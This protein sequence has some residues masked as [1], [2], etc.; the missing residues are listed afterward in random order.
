MKTQSNWSA[1]AL[2]Y[3]VDW[4]RAVTT[5]LGALIARPREVASVVPSS[6]QLEDGLSKLVKEFAPSLVVELGPGTGGTTK[7][8]L[9][10]LSADAKLISIEI[11]PEFVEELRQI[12]DPRLIVCQGDAA[13]LSRILSESESKSVDLVVSGIPFSTMRPRVAKALVADIHRSLAPGGQ[14]VTYQVRDTIIEIATELFNTPRVSLVFWNVPPLRLYQFAKPCREKQH[15]HPVC[16]AMDAIA[17][18]TSFEG[19]QD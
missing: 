8:L 12:D 4:I 9:R 2:D 19:R 18:T 10:S 5:F 6:Q 3:V 17:I 7:A 16:S 1:D 13:D 14:F 15:A 11:V